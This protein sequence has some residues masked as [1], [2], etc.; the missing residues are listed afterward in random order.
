MIPYNENDISD[1]NTSVT[2]SVCAAIRN[3]TDGC[4]VASWQATQAYAYHRL[5]RVL[6][7]KRDGAELCS[8]V[9]MDLTA[10]TRNAGP[11]AEKG[12]V[13]AKPLPEVLVAMQRHSRNPD[14]I[15]VSLDFMEAL[16]KYS[17]RK[18]EIVQA[19]GIPFSADIIRQGGTDYVLLEKACGVI[20]KL[21]F[22][23]PENQESFAANKRIEGLSQLLS[24]HQTIPSVMEYALLALTGVSANNPQNQVDALKT[25]CLEVLLRVLTTY[26]SK[27]PK[28]VDA[29]CSAMSAVVVPK[30]ATTAQAFGVLKAPELIVRA[31]KRHADSVA[32]QENASAALAAFCEAEPKTVS[33]L[34][35]T[36]LSSVLVVALQRFLH[37][38]PAV[39]QIFRAMRA[40]TNEVNEEDSYRFKSK[41]LTDRSNESSLAEIFHTALQYHKKG[42]PGT[43][44]V[45]ISICATINRL[46]MRS[47]AFK[48]EVG[49]DGIVEELTRLVEKTAEFFEIK[50]LQ[51]VLAT[52]CTLVLDSEDNK[53]RFHAVGGVEAILDVMQRWK[54]DT[55]VLEHCCAALRYSCNDHFGNCDEVKIHN[56][57]RSILSV[58]ELYPENVN[59]TLWCCLTL[60]DLCKG[61]EELQSSRNV[62]QGIR[63][64]ISAMEMFAN[65]S[66]FLA[67]ACEFL[68]AAS[69]DN[70]GNQERI[71]RLG[72]RTA[73]VKALESHPGDNGLTESGA[74][75]L[76]QIQHINP[77]RESHDSAPQLGIV[78]RFSRELRRSGS[79]A[80][81]KGR[82]RKSLSFTSRRRTSEKERDDALAGLSQ[83]VGVENPATRGSFFSLEIGERERTEEIAESSMTKKTMILNLAVQETVTET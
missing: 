7:L 15:R 59:V 56:G 42:L 80:S 29:S 14:F 57:V 46:C 75:A 32:V 62:I 34:P 52:I 81:R 36:G 82:A 9:V 4:S 69:M 13:D 55:Y 48:N 8:I 53:N 10:I 23:S 28:V 65:N 35:K 27:N 76:L 61:D 26:S 16:C 54:Q 18:T 6:V 78:K 50:A 11:G 21:C 20:E 70:P 17:P 71:V 58:M 31:M 66:R 1:L 24:S 77:V 33:A 68:R 45:I 72:G 25:G 37:R 74:Y 64:V 41:L 5:V 30:N 73:I 47:V 38:Q 63:K 39:I 12:L 40:I 19:G 79:N 60:A 67:S 83:T 43:A 51:P 2:K 49:K 44:N 22:D 3:L